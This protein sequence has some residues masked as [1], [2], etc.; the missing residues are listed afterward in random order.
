MKT[1]APSSAGKKKNKES[2]EEQCFHD[3]EPSMLERAWRKH[4]VN[5]RLGPALT[6]TNH[7]M[8]QPQAHTARKTR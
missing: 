3:Y 1:A 5:W 8:H 4:T 7:V 2:E 6:A